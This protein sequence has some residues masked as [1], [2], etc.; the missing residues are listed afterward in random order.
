MD[1]LFRDIYVAFIRVHLLH[2]A[3]EAPFYGLEML[4]ELARHGYNLSPGTLYPLLHGLEARGLLA[5]EQRVVNGKIRKYYSTTPKGLHALRQ[6]RPQ[7]REL[8]REVLAEDDLTSCEE[9]SID[10]D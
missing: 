9:K 10:A 6:L 5:C 4:E 2:H 3:A 1:G 7:I 8:V